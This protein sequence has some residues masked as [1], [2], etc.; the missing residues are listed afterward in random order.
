[1][2]VREAFPQRYEK[3]IVY[4]FGLLPIEMAIKEEE[5]KIE[6]LQATISSLREKAKRS[7]SWYAEATSTN[8]PRWNEFNSKG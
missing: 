6:L 1:L 4:P 2:A 3:G 5:N 7:M 8:H